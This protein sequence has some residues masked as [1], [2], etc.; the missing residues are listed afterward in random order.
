MRYDFSVLRY[1]RKS[2]SPQSQ[3][4][5]NIWNLCYAYEKNVIKKVIRISKWWVKFGLLIDLKNSQLF[6]K[7]ITDICVSEAT[8][9]Y[10][11]RIWQH[12]LF[13]HSDN[14]PGRSISQSWSSVTC[15][16]W[17]FHFGPMWPYSHRKEPHPKDLDYSFT[18]PIYSHLL[19]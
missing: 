10:F 12:G 15:V 1:I 19:D 16:K 2:L 7:K 5:G 8:K 18:M 4:P 11:N 13:N 17:H 6:L 14:I 9:Y 3:Q